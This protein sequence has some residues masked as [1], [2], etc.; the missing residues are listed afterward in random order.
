M[1]FSFP[2][3]GYARAVPS[4]GP[5]PFHSRSERAQVR[6]E[7]APRLMRSWAGRAPRSRR[8]SRS[9]TLPVA[10]FGVLERRGGVLGVAR[11]LQRRRGRT[12]AALGLAIC[13]PGLALCCALLVALP[14]ALDTSIADPGAP[15]G[16]LKPRRRS[17]DPRR[18]PSPSGAEA[19]PLRPPSGARSSA[20]RCCS[21]AATNASRYR[22]R[23]SRGGTFGTW[24]TA[25][26]GEPSGGP[27]PRRGGAA[28]GEYA[29]RL[30][31]GPRGDSPRP[32]SVSPSASFPAG[33]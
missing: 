23:R 13:V 24:G 17:R 9:C 11:L 31:A 14:T 29:V 25:S 4:F 10:P 19:S 33:L 30:V 5:N 22:P 28:P 1:V 16:G 6:N 20:P 2:A 26:R 32:Y 18:A 3:R 21:A 12:F 8:G 15:V 7:T 27:I